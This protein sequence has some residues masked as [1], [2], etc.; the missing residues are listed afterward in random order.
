MSEPG[1]EFRASARPI[2]KGK[3]RLASSRLELN[4]KVPEP[5]PDSAAGRPIEAH[6]KHQA[7]RYGERIPSRELVGS[8]TERTFGLHLGRWFSTSAGFSIRLL[9]AALHLLLLV[10]AFLLLALIVLFV[11]Y[12]TVP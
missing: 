9:W 11:R 3:Q 5:A 4:S 7:E 1:V 2:R 8:D 6:W 10:A 12:A